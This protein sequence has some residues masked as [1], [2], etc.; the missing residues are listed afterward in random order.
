VL[1][2][3]R[4]ESEKKAIAVEVS[5]AAIHAVATWGGERRRGREIAAAALLLLRDAEVI[6]AGAMRSAWRESAAD[7][8]AGSVEILRGF[9]A[10]ADATP[11][12]A[13]KKFSTT[14]RKA[15]QEEGEWQSLELDD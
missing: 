6:A 11:K 8:R 12:I 7:E 4:H 9:V 15:V 1:L 13:L 2:Q 10:A 3:L 5:K 14:R